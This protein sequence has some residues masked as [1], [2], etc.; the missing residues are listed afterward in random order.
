MQ[1]SPY[2]NIASHAHPHPPHERCYVWF[3]QEQNYIMLFPDITTAYIYASNSIAPDRT[4]VIWHNNICT[5]STQYNNALQLWPILS[6]P[7]R[8]LLLGLGSTIPEWL[9]ALY[10]ETGYSVIEYTPQPRM[11]WPQFPTTNTTHPTNP[12]DTYT[13]Q[14]T[15]VTTPPFRPQPTPIDLLQLV[16]PPLNSIDENP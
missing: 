4:D 16:Y 8:Q 5:I 11:N 12:I 15:A 1:R 3:R 13:E 7:G 9:A 10:C 14:T 6:T 2:C